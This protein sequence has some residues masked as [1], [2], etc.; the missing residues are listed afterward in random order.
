MASADY[1]RPSFLR[2]IKQKGKIG[3]KECANKTECKR[4]EKSWGD[5]KVKK[6]ISL[7][8]EQ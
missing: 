5:Q 4:R 7:N 3:G 8:A 1:K 2:S 6:I